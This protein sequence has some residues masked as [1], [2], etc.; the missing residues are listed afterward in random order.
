MARLELF[1]SVPV[2]KAGVATDHDLLSLGEVVRGVL[3]QSQN[4]QRVQRGK[5][6]RNDLGRVQNIESEFESLVFLDNLSIELPLRVV[7]RG[8]GVPEIRTVIVRVL[9]GDML[10]LVPHQT[11]LALLGLPVPLDELRATVVGHETECVNTKAVL[12]S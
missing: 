5:L 8:D 11:G 9:S 12:F 2:W 4:S 3:I 6:L 10:S 7:P 1:S